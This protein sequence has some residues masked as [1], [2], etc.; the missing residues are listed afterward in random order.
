MVL[1]HRLVTSTCQRKSDG[2]IDQYNYVQ[3]LHKLRE[4]FKVVVWLSLTEG[5]RGSF[6]E[7]IPNQILSVLT[8]YPRISPVFPKLGLL[9]GCY[10]PRYGRK[11]KCRVALEYEARNLQPPGDQLKGCGE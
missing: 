2:R 6:G 10:V 3:L 8:S 11:D 5:L 1:Q 4:G 7:S 9:P